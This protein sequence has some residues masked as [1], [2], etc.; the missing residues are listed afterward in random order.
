MKALYQTSIGVATNI[1][2]DAT[3]TCTAPE[4]FLWVIPS[5]DLEAYH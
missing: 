2:M 1:F 5:G 4:Q 3:F